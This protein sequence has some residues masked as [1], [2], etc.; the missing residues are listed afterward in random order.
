[1]SDVTLD[2]GKVLSL[3]NSRTSKNYGVARNLMP[4]TVLAKRSSK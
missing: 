3:L 2:G 1:M 4:A